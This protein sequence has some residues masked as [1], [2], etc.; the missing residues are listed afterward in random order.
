MGTLVLPANTPLLVVLEFTQVNLRC[1]SK[2]LRY[3]LNTH[4]AA[5]DTLNKT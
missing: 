2:R 1:L 3:L 4:N 5:V